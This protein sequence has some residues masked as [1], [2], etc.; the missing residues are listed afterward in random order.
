MGLGLHFNPHA[1]CGARHAVGILAEEQRAI[2]ILAP[3]TGRDN[4]HILVAVGIIISILAPRTG[5]DIQSDIVM[6]IIKAFQS[7]RPVR[8]ATLKI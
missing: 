5:R 1:P 7:A 8:G 2:S 3:R 6:D 4:D